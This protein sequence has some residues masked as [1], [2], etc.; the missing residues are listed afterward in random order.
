[1]NNHQE[2]ELIKTTR[3]RPCFECALMKT[4]WFGDSG[5]VAGFS[6]NKF[7]AKEGEQT[8]LERGQPGGQRHAKFTVKQLKDD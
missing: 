8:I 5:H 3:P 4:W 2:A 1:M 6:T 7:E